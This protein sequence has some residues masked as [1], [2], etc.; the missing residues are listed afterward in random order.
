MKLCIDL[1][2]CY[3]INHLC[4]DFEF[5]DDNSLFAIYA[6]NGIMKT[7]FA[8]TCSDFTAGNE[9]KD[10]I[11][12]SKVTA[13]KL[14]NENAIEISPES[15][16]VIHS[17]DESF[18]SKR[19]SSLLVNQE[20][21]K[22]Y[23]EI[24][25]VISDK[26]EN[27]IKKL[28]SVSGLKDDGEIEK[29]VS[30][31]FSGENDKFFNVLI[32]THELVNE[33]IDLKFSTIKY[34][35]VFDADVLKF[36][37]TREFRDTLKKYVDK[38]EELL[39][40]TKF[41][42]KGFDHY[43]A[44]TV[45]KNL[46]S[47][48]YFKAKHTINLVTDEG[49]QEVSSGKELKDI[50]QE[51]KDSVFENDEIKTIFNEIDKKITNKKL[52][53]FRTFL[54]ENKTLVH[55]LSD[56]TKLRKN[57]WL[58]YLRSC[59][60]EYNEL[61][62]VYKTNQPKLLDVINKA[63]TEATDWEHVINL[64]NKRFYVPFDVNLINKEDIMLKD[65]VPTIG[66]SYKDR[67][68]PVDRELLG[69]VLSRGE[70][71][72]L[73]LLN[74]MFEVESR[75]KVGQN[76]VFVIDDIADSFDYKNKYA[77]VQYLKEI[78]EH[79]LFSVIL[80]THNFDFFRTVQERI[81]KVKW[82]NSLMAFRKENEIVLD[83]VKSRYISNPL[84]MWKRDL[85]KEEMYL[86]ASISF[87]RNLC[88][89]S[90]DTANFDYLTQLLHIKSNTKNI[91]YS[92]IETLYN[93]VFTGLQPF[94]HNPTLKVYDRIIALS[95]QFSQEPDD[96][97]N[98]EKKIVLSI[99]IRLKAEEYMISTINDQGFVDQIARNQTGE[100]FG[101]YK[102]LFPA[103]QNEISVLDRVSLMTPENIHLNSF[104]FEPILD[105]SMLHL[106][107]LYNEVN[108]L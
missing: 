34:R 65:E 46:D 107:D 92:D 85:P 61:V 64:F 71:R 29:N 100:L 90:G 70:L 38:Y 57:F 52:R 53:D 81:Q 41:L 59:K 49:K 102:E 24:Y 63:K 56:L 20:L 84:K 88:E 44:Q 79:D 14:V 94:Q 67:D 1:K 51:E 5:K 98:L 99:G 80:L 68:E 10:Q 93:T 3:G 103:N 43:N 18:T 66:Y 89:Y 27:L 31:Y 32:D 82:G 55:E 8:K 101:K 25:N 37:E 75:K 47:N 104:M 30:F 96:G 72:A 2:N 91:S 19:I 105:M 9:S 22:E 6:P 36:L 33:E 78:A 23:D 60:T 21:K 97:L 48:N 54:F 28:K 62:N 108:V 17:L 11:H 86:M 74:V 26:K 77:I 7:S 13:R 15:M 42:K 76:T 50:I 73:Y 58:D 106:Q 87:V 4:Y 35:S 95:D 40:K 83:T 45:Q 16:F 39:E 12:P 69:N